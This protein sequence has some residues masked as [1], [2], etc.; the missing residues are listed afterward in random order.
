MLLEIAAG[1][2]SKSIR[3]VLNNAIEQYLY[4]DTGPIALA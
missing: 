2:F 1:L 3:L 4:E